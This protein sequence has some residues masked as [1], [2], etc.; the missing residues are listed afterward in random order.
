MMDAAR[1]G[2]LRNRSSSREIDW[3]AVVT[4]LVFLLLPSLAIAESPFKN[5]DAVAANVGFNSYGSTTFPHKVKVAVLDNG[6]KG[7]SAEVGKSLPSSVQFHAGPIAVDVSTE[8]S[9]GLAMAQILSGLLKKV[10]GLDYELH[11]YSAF[12]Y[13]NLE[14]AVKDVAQKK[15]DIVLYSQ[16]WEYG[17]NG[18]GKGFINSLVNQATQAGVIWLNASGNFADATYSA[19]VVAADDDWAKLPGSN[20]SIKIRCSKNPKGKCPFRAVLSWNDFKDDVSMGTD[21]DLDL[22]LTDDTLKIIRTSGLQQVKVLPPTGDAGTSLYPREIIQTE[23]DPGTYLLR[24]KIRSRNFTSVDKLKITTSG[25][26]TE[27]LNVTP[28]DETL[29][30]PADNATVITVGAT[31]SPKSGRSVRFTKPELLTPSAMVLKNGDTYKGSSNSAAVAAAAAVVLKAL[32]LKLDREAVIKSL[33]GA[34]IHAIPGGSIDGVGDGV[35]H[36]LPLSFLQFGPTRPD[37]FEPATLPAAFPAAQRLLDAGAVGVAT[38]SGVKIFTEVDPLKLFPRQPRNRVDDMYVLNSLGT[39]VMS[40][41][42]QSQLPQNSYEIVQQPHG[43]RICRD[44]EDGGIGGGVDGG[45]TGNLLRL[46]RPR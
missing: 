45:S 6:F 19:P 5:L 12:G 3:S 37:C 44:G 16:V 13:S 8:E 7:Y 18:D 38:T 27:Q 9:H 34:A 33:S 43:T 15:F 36:G 2:T 30:S 14:A 22:V 42:F 41:T 11:L 25:D 4:L 39:T 10:P 29:L 17:G 20:N 21:K 23:L 24:V 46:P 31:D 32:D 1:S 26:Y 28:A 40:R 35:G